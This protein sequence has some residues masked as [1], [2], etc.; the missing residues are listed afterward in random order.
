MI[1]K[2][3]YK[4]IDNKGIIPFSVKND[5]TLEIL[6]EDKSVEG[7]IRTFKAG[8]TFYGELVACRLA[9]KSENGSFVPN[10]D[11]VG[12]MVRN[13]N[14]SGCWLIPVKQAIPMDDNIIKPQNQDITRLDSEDNLSLIGNNESLNKCSCK[15]DKILGFSYMQLAIIGA[16]LLIVKNI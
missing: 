6:T 13:E 7:S 16:L 9:T 15:E 1:T 8:G 14:N 5:L 4:K 3:Q 12:L 2:I 10:G 11:G